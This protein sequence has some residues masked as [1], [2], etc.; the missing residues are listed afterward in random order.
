MVYGREI[1]PE[2]IA[3]GYEAVTLEDVKELAN[4]IFDFDKMSLAAVGKI[5][6]IDEYKKSAK[7]L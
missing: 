2:E 6:E 7:V 3:A 4:L 5:S 1:T